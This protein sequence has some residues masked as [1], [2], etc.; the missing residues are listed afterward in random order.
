MEMIGESGERTV[1]LV[2]TPASVC[3]ALFSDRPF[4]FIWLSGNRGGMHG[5]PPEKA[6]GKGGEGGMS[7]SWRGEGGGMVC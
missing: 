1:H 4:K 6:P 3:D 2:T 7:W 5:T